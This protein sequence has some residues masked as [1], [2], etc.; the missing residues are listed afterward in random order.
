MHR[1]NILE[2]VVR[3]KLKFFAS[4]WASYDS[5]VPGTFHLVPPHSRRAEL[6]RDLNAMRPMLLNA[7][8]TFTELLQELTQAEAELNAKPNADPHSSNR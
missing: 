1:R 4:F 8:Q 5:A 2:D 6:A 3:H 7:Q